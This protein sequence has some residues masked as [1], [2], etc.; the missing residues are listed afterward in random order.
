MNSD[1]NRT[2]T[3]EEAKRNEQFEKHKAE[4][5]AEGYK[6]VDLTTSVVRA[7]VMAIVLAIPFIL[8]FGVIYFLVNKVTV[9]QFWDQLT[10]GREIYWLAIYI[11]G[12][13]ALIIIHELIHGVARAIFAK[14]G[15]KAI[16]FG[17]IKKYLTP[18]CVC[19]EPLTR[20]GYLF[21]ALMPGILLGFIPCI[22]SIIIGNA[23]VFSVGIMMI[24]AAGGDL[25]SSFKLITFRTKGKKAIYIDHPYLVGLAAFVKE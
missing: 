14:S 15:W 12:F 16:Q 20:F 21:G 6:E 8:I 22:V 19:T 23:F 5:E 11:V 1:K 4:L 9:I 7:N 2:L 10:I 13:F 3:A 18:Y 25:Y 24:L 17:F